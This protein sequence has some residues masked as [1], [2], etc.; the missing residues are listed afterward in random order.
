VAAVAAEAAAVVEAEASLAEAAE[1]MEEE[2]SDAA[3]TAW[4][5]D[6]R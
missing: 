2:A 3:A 1:V 6:P 4:T 5:P